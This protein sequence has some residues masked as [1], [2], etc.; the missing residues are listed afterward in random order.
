[1]LQAYATREPHLAK[2][3]TFQKYSAAIKTPVHKLL[4]DLS[5]LD[6]D[7]YVF[8]C[9]AWNMGLVR[10]AIQTLLLTQPNAYFLLGGPQVMHH[11]HKYLDHRHPNLM[12][13]N[14]EGERTFAQL[15]A[16][17]TEH[18]PDLSRVNGLSFYRDHELLTTPDEPRIMDLNEI[19]SPFL[20]GVYEDNY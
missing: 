20:A 2:A 8:S 13:C 6:A 9:Y 10:R 19:P 11:S 15:L 5:H 14:G 4:N 1:Y 3:Y 16:E 18:Q 17:L 12:L 7:L